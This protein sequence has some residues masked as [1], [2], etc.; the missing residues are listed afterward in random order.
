MED[1]TPYS[2]AEVSRLMGFSESTV[3]KLFEHEPGVLIY[4]VPRLRKR[5]SYRTIRIP[6][7]V[8]ERYSA[9]FRE[10]N[11]ARLTVCGL[12]SYLRLC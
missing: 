1:I 10:I 9:D 6:R 4:E 12:L 11:G 3:T 5:K 7:H 8:Y 2:V